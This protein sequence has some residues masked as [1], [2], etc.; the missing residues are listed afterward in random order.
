MSREHAKLWI[1]PPH[2]RVS[3]RI[4][5]GSQGKADLFVQSVYL[6]D[7]G[8]MH[9]TFVQRQSLPKDTMHIVKNGETITFGI[10]VTRGQG[11]A[12]AHAH[13]LLLS[14]GCLLKKFP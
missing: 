1:S 11:T 2:S 3:L 5:D 12:H 13:A 7:V 6:K 9:G 10:E 4:V 14:K 8:S